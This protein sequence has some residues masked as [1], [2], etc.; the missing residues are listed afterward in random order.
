M[1]AIAI[2]QY[3]LHIQIAGYI[4]HHQ[5]K[6]FVVI[7]VVMIALGAFPIYSK[8]ALKNYDLKD[9]KIP[10]SLLA[11]AI[12]SPVLSCIENIQGGNPSLFFV[13]LPMA[14]SAWIIYRNRKKAEA[15]KA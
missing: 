14:I 8:R 10:R 6:S 1:I 12:S 3:L 4:A 11:L 9:P 2:I 7:A 13:T 5:V 15:A